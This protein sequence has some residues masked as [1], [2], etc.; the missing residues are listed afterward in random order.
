MLA[1]TD[2]ICL[3]MTQSTNP[4]YIYIYIFFSSSLTICCVAHCL[5]VKSKRPFSVC[6]SP[7]AH[8]KKKL[9]DKQ[10]QQEPMRCTCWIACK[11]NNIAWNKWSVGC[12]IH[13][14]FATILFGLRSSSFQIIVSY[15]TSI[16]LI[17]FEPTKN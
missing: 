13:F 12:Y 11:N 7:H 17:Y 8:T 5:Q 4:K 9:S 2:F 16:N 6:A 15:N 1:C 3:C 14:M 10:K